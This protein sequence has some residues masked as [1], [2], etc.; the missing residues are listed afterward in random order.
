MQTSRALGLVGGISWVSTQDYYRLL[1]EGVNQRLGG[2]NFARLIIQSLNFREFVE[3]NTA[4]RWDRTLELMRTACAS[5]QAAGAEGL[6]LCANTAHAVIAPLKAE[7]DLPF[8]DVVEETAA[9][10]SA[11]RLRKVAL[12][13][14]QF[15]MEL[16]FYRDGLARHGIDA[17][18]PAD[19][20]QRDYIQQT[21]R[22]ELGRGIARAETRAA[23]L[24]I[25]R[26]MIADGC[27]GVIFGCTEIPLL[28]TPEDF[29]V[30]CFDTMRIH[31]S[32]GVRFLLG[33][34]A[35]PV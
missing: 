18:V 30:P 3:N 35:A 31:A 16:P 10:I 24:D 26:A 6:M 7:F 22:D 12:I 27:E 33:E 20:A 2:L 4:G 1:N 11:A 19:Q 8:I 25:L 5:L 32:A 15:T 17:V 28:L 34:D 9:T 13:G 29:S 21:V 23:Y 14:T